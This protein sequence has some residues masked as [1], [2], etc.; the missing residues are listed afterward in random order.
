M[1][2]SL[3][4]VQYENENIPDVLFLLQCLVWLISVY[5]RFFSLFHLTY[6]TYRAEQI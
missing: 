4:D 5:P 2:L 3:I 1:T 6:G